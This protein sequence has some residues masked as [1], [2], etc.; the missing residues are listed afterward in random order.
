MKALLEDA[1]S[2]NQK[3]LVERFTVTDP[4]AVAFQ[5]QGVFMGSPGQEMVGLPD[6]K[7]QMC[8]LGAFEDYVYLRGGTGIIES[9][10][11]YIRI[12]GD[13]QVNCGQVAWKRY[14]V[15]DGDL[16]SPRGCSRTSAGR[17]L[18]AGLELVTAVCVRSMVWHVSSRM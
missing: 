10:E 3:L 2:S 7:K 5:G 15:P 9:G 4:T 8:K 12:Y 14:S 1:S 11:D 6:D 17:T 18:S 13:V 16:R